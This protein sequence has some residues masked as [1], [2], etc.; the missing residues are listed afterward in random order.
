[1]EVPTPEV[2]PMC[3]EDPSQLSSLTPIPGTSSASQDLFKRKR[4]TELQM[5]MAI[6]A[7]RTGRMSIKLAGQVFGIP[8]MT[9]WS[10]TRKLG[11]ASSYSPRGGGKLIDAN[12]HDEEHDDVGGYLGSSH[13]LLSGSSMAECEE[14]SAAIASLRMRFAKTMQ[15]INLHVNP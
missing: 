10:R 7:V 15:P 13:A 6:E 5:Q 12:G 3:L 9:V 1:M 8:T 2:Q 4:W 14:I 11:I